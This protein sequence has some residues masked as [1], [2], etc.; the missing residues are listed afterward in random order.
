MIGQ[1]RTVAVEEWLRSIPRANGTKSKIR[2]TMSA[3]FNHAI[4]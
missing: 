1:I 2:N 4:R 3:L